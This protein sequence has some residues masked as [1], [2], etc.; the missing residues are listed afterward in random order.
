MSEKVVTYIS[1]DGTQVNICEDCELIL[2]VANEWP[3]DSQGQEI[4]TVSR[5]LHDAPCESARHGRRALPMRRL[6]PA[7]GA[8]GMARSRRPVEVD[9]VP[10]AERGSAAACGAYVSRPYSRRVRVE[11]DTCAD[12]VAYVYD[13]NGPTEELDPWVQIVDP[14]SRI[15]GSIHVGPGDVVADVAKAR[16]ERGKVQS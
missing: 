3:R 6:S 4:C 9:Y 16:G 10:D 12:V 1:P 13:E 15:A 2:S 8:R 5:G 11:R 7:I 14:V